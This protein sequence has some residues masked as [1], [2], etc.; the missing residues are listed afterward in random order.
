MSSG[1]NLRN[2]LVLAALALPVQAQTPSQPFVLDDIIVSGGFT[3]I[4]ANAYGRAVSVLT[5]EDIRAKGL[6]TVQDALRALPGVSV[7]SAGSTQTQVR[8]RGAEASHTLILIDGVEAAGGSDEYILT[9]LETDN[10]ERIEVL[11]G[12]QSVFYGSN[13]SAGVINIITRKGDQGLHYGGSVEAGNGVGAALN[14]S[15]R[16]ERGGLSFTA[17]ARDDHGYDQSGDGGEKDGTRRATIGLSGDWQASEDVTLGF[18]L[19]HADEDYDF[20]S[21]DWAAV[22]AAGYV[23]D[24]PTQ[25]SHRDELTAAAWAE[26]RMMDGRLIHR[27]E[28]QDSTLAQSRNGGPETTGKTRK[29]KYRLSVGLDGAADSA[30]QIV[31]VLAEKQVDESDMAPNYER[32]TKSLA[33]EYR[34]QFANGF[35]LQAGLRYDDNT[36]FEDFTGWTLGLSWKIP[37]TALRLHASAGRAQVNPAFYDLFVDDPYT[38]GNPFLKPERNTGF[39]LGL[40]AEIL[41]G[42]GIVDV[43]YFNEKMTDE[44]TWVPGGATDGSGRSSYVNQAGDSPRQGLELSGRVQATDDLSLGFSATLLDASNPDGSVEIRRPRTE[45]ALSGTLRAFGGRGSVT[46]DLRHVSGNFDTQFWGAYP[47]LELPAFTTVD[48]SARY[49]LA[50]HVTIRGRVSNLF[51]VDAVEVWGYAAPERTAWVGVEANW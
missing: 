4:A 38:L 19:R 30:T 9:G 13:A 26:Y 10:I 32:D 47:T 31:N 15:Q 18:T 17:S 46:A 21:A 12:P 2:G 43:T 14:L 24:D 8:I 49:D 42:R 34:G 39:D 33:L 45:I 36:P 37:D 6:Q 22:D 25:T 11:R 41:E 1:H 23:V 3:D 51:N 20:D 40:E 27:L 16:G 48:L 44:I 29:L 28:V 35:D 7:S 5:A 50:D